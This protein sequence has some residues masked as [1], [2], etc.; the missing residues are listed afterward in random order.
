MI[1]SMKIDPQNQ[2]YDVE[3]T[4]FNRK[5]KFEKIINQYYV[6]WKSNNKIYNQNKV[7]DFG[8]FRYF[9]EYNVNTDSLS[10]NWVKTKE[11]SGTKQ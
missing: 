1:Y 6:D 9:I 8:P 7:F 10:E 11:K 3:I 2:Y 5:N 4:Y